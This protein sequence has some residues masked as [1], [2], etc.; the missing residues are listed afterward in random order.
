MLSRGKLAD[1]VVLSEPLDAVAPE[2]IRKIQV[3]ATMLDG[4]FVYDA[5]GELA[6]AVP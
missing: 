2:R 1:L 4:E 3:R 6:P 5:A